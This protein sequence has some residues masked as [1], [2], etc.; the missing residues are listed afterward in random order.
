MNTVSRSINFDAWALPWLDPRCLRY[1]RQPF[2]ASHV[3]EKTDMSHGMMRKEVLCAR[4][5]AHQ[6]HVFDDGPKPTGL[7]WVPSVT[8]W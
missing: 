7:R 2:E 1:A 4:C 3:W 8:L 5:K 6:G